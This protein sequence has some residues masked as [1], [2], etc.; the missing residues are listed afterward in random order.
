LLV[1]KVPG[2]P[3]LELHKGAPALGHITQDVGELERNPQFDGIG[4][5]TRA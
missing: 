4:N 1:G 5:R 3:D 2:P